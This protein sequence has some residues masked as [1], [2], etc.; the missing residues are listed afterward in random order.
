MNVIKF[1]GVLLLCL[2][3]K[4]SRVDLAEKGLAEKGLA[5]A[6]R[7]DCIGVLWPSESDEPIRVVEDLQIPDSAER[8]AA[9]DVLMDLRIA[10]QD[11]TA[12]RAK[13]G[14]LVADLNRAAHL[15]A[16]KFNPSSRR[17]TYVIVGD[18]GKHTV[19]IAAEATE[20]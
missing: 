8:L 15:R 2:T 7:R 9:Q 12:D 10:Y 1:L 19:G 6:L 4:P 18:V 5:G 14:R 20:T 17:P 13:V 11:S 16:Y 3:A